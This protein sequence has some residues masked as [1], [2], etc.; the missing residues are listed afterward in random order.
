[1]CRVHC[2]QLTEV[3]N[4]GASEVDRELRRKPREAPSECGA[5]RR[6]PRSDGAVTKVHR[7]DFGD[8]TTCILTC[9]KSGAQRRTP[10]ALR[11]VVI[12]IHSTCTKSARERRTP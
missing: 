10:K 4:F 5:P 9:E 12:D 3:F 7:D 11:A 6:F 2:A 1:M 8:V